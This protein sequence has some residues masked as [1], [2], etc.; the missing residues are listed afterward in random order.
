MLLLTMEKEIHK[1][2]T[3]K[4]KPAA[5]GYL[6][7]AWCL[8]KMHAAQ[9]IVPGATT[10]TKLHGCSSAMNDVD[11]TTCADQGRR[12]KYTKTQTT[13]CH[14]GGHTRH[15]LSIRPRLSAILVNPGIADLP[16]SYGRK[17]K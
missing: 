6:A 17:K 14:L 11:I 4:R 5:R 12:I 9:A 10:S 13:S 8:Q 16:P 15:A 7:S 1:I 2:R 3:L